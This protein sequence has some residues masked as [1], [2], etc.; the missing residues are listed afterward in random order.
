MPTPT[1][2]SRGPRGPYLLYLLIGSLPFSDFLQTGI[3][4]FSAAPVMGDIAAS[5]E[6]YSSVATLYAVVA[7]AVIA[8]HRQL[9]DR[10]GWRRMVQG[11][12]LFFASGAVVC[13]LSQ[14]LPL[15]ALGRVLMALGCASFLTAG[16]VLVN[17]IPLSPR[18][19]TGIK[20]FASGLAWGGVAGPWLA[21]A[22]LASHSWRLG[23]FALLLPAAII[24]MLASL[25]LDNT[26]HDQAKP[27]LALPRSL[28]LLIGGSFTLL[29]VL[30]RSNYDFFNGARLLW[31]GALLALIA[32]AMFVWLSRRDAAAP[33]AF[34]PLAQ[35]RYLV[36]LGMFAL[37][38]LVLG[39]N[40]T[41]LP[42][43][44]QRALGLPLEVIGRYM[45]IGA[46]A[47][48]ASWIVV[49]RLMPK[50]PGP[51]RYYL[52]GFAA[53]LAC[54]LRLSSISEAADPW[55]SVLPALLCNG[56]F[57]ILA[58]STTAMQTF[59][60]LQRDEVTFS[61]ANQVKSMLGQF[62]VAAGTALATLCLQWRSSLHYAHLT[63]SLSASNGALQPSL[64]L[65]TRWFAAAQDT[66]RAP[67][68]ALA[69]LGL[70]VNQEATLMGAL[71]YFFA[72]ALLAGFCMCMVA[73]EGLWRV[74]RPPR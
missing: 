15:F 60:T 59:Q 40:N 74:R 35:R 65:L 56:A 34:R 64:A 22:A 29:H 27:H 1:T 28:L 17:H 48:V 13:G 36:G 37:C 11:A 24:F 25:A 21:A 73:I 39:A 18:R 54:G 6:E 53:L 47:G 43:L 19:F 31:A 41:M 67:A 58:L 4:A 70:W 50:S 69:Q 44:L 33:I 3:V 46:L 72:V 9:L 5:P 63:E 14:G 32:L 55:R 62:G 10:L 51:T 68:M 52:A 45:G 30:Q 66:A 16:R 71:D 7:I 61:H 2:A 26:P 57:V 8:V 49:S 20:F 42:V 12:S 38:Y 23:F